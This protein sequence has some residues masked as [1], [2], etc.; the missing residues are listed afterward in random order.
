MSNWVVDGYSGSG[1]LDFFCMLNPACLLFKSAQLFCTCIIISCIV[2]VFLLFFG[3]KNITDVSR[4][5][6]KWDS[7]INVK[8]ISKSDNCTVGYKCS[9]PGATLRSDN[10]CY[11]KINGANGHQPAI[12]I[13]IQPCNKCS[14]SRNYS[15]PNSKESSKSYKAKD[16]SQVATCD[17]IPE[18]TRDTLNQPI[19]VDPKNQYNTSFT[20]TTSERTTGFVL[21]IIGIVCILSIIGFVYFTFEKIKQLF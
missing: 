20:S 12:P 18:S 13:T 19:Y 14:Y 5:E 4:K 17:N 8:T 9:L 11:S 1:S 2:A 15:L 21:T 16:I 10:N 7:K 3:I 6:G